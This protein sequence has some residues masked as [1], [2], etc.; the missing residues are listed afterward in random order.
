MRSVSL[1]NIGRIFYFIIIII[2]IIIIVF[3]KNRQM[4]NASHSFYLSISI[5]QA[6]LNSLWEPCAWWVITVDLAPVCSTFSPLASKSLWTR[7]QRVCVMH[8]ADIAWTSGV[9]DQKQKRRMAPRWSLKESPRLILLFVGFLFFPQTNQRS[10][11]CEKV[12]VKEGLSPESLFW[13]LPRVES[14]MYNE[15]VFILQ[16]NNLHECILFR[17][18]K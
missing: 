6:S 14:C 4:L 17:V 11:L 18:L 16:I 15:I 9:E 1:V 3:K 10:S 7:L 8:Q 5:P 13:H 12:I 2:K